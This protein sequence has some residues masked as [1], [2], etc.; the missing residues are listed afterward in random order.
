MT[1]GKITQEEIDEREKILALLIDL[2]ENYLGNLQALADALG[3]KKPTLSRMFAGQ[4]TS[5]TLNILIKKVHKEICCVNEKQIAN[6]SASA[7]KTSEP[8]RPDALEL[9][10]EYSARCRVT[11]AEFISQALL[12]FG[13]ETALELEKREAAR[14]A[15]PQSPVDNPAK[16][17]PAAPEDS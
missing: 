13:R 15:P 1:I 6:E 4:K 11:P 7:Y 3:V 17:K 5:D 14:I 8:L 9:L 2:R 12:R 10:H 16:K